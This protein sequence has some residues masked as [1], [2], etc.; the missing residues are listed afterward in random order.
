MPV[1]VDVQPVAL[2]SH[3][4]ALNEQQLRAF[5]STL[6]VQIVH[7]DEAILQRDELIARKD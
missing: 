5:A 7:R 6:L 4:D 1:M 3:L 2:L